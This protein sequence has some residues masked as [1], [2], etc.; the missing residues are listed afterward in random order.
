MYLC[1]S[2][3]HKKHRALLYEQSYKNIGFFANLTYVQVVRLFLLP[4]AKVP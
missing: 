2:V 1:D 4:D 3:K